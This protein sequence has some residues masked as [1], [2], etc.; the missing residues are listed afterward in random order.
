MNNQRS[1]RSQRRSS[2]MV[3]LVAVLAVTMMFT[4]CF[5]GG[6]FAKYTSSATGT[7][8]T[9]V[10]KWDIRVNGSE[11]ATRDTF[12]FELFQT[13]TDSDL[14]S[15]ETDMAP[16]DG[17]IIAPGTSGKF[18]I[19]IQ[20]LSQ[21]NAKYTIDYTVTNTSSIPV[22]FSTDGSDWKTNIN[23]LNVTD[24]AIGLGTEETVTV[25]WRWRFEAD[26]VT[27]GDNLDTSLGSADPAATLTVVANVTATQVD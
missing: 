16:A 15:A 8:S 20:N 14:S 17:S 11:I 27:V 1:Q 3:R 19:A 2:M 12:T 13:I 21:V 24:D 25:Y 26:N 10:A 4:M 23:Q 18:S 5:V 22:E 6:T 7:D 9:T